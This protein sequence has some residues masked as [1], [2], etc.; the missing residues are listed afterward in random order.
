MLQEFPEGEP[1][2][3]ARLL[4]EDASIT[5][6]AV[7]AARSLVCWMCVITLSP[8]LAVIMLTLLA[9]QAAGKHDRLSDTR[10]MVASAVNALTGSDVSLVT[11]DEV[12]GEYF[13]STKQASMGYHPGI[14]E[15]T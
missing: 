12:R 2:T 9:Q 6:A 14:V 11:R 8:L 10:R 13:A 1:R 15:R 3:E 4:H 7:I 5:V